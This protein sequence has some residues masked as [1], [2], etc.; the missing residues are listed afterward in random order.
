MHKLI[1]LP[2]AQKDLREITQYIA[3]T[4]KAP[5]AAIDLVDAFDDAITRLQQ[6]PYAFRIYQPI[7]SLEAEY[8]LLPVKNY[9][10]ILCSDRT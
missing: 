9:L 6:F 5:K 4:L 2:L 1:Y 8:R 7:Q 10:G 3:E